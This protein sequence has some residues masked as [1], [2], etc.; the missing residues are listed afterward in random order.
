MKNLLII[1]NENNIPK[2]ILK[3]FI[4]NEDLRLFYLQSIIDFNYS[5]LI[6]HEHNIVILY[7][8]DIKTLHCVCKNIKELHSI[9]LINDKNIKIPNFYNKYIYK[10]VNSLDNIYGSLNFLFENITNKTLKTSIHTYLFEL[11]Y[12]FSLIGTQYLLESINYIVE[13]QIFEKIN[14]EKDVYVKLAEKHNVSTNNIKCN[15][16]LATKRMSYTFE[17]NHIAN[18]FFN[19]IITTKYVIK[20]FILNY[21]KSNKTNN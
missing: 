15:I 1:D 21:C 4:K 2:E 18:N 8:N 11:G 3:K 17:K 14:L 5:D 20:F 13:N 6:F 19:D 16:T 10:Q 7:L 12:N 9:I